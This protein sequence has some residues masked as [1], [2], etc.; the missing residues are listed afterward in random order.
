MTKT[1]LSVLAVLAVGVGGVVLI[2]SSGGNAGEVQSA[3]QNGTQ[4]ASAA[5]PR[6]DSPPSASGNLVVELCDGKTAAEIPG[7]KE[8]ETPSREQARAVV[9]H[10]MTDW[11]RKNPDASW[12][13]APMRVAQ[14]AG[15]A[16]TSGSA[17]APA[18]ATAPEIA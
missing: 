5:M 3:D 12:D 15:A 6:H 8:G 9:D 7:V 11:R 4:V 17:A 13:D 16:G 1:I 14:A 2:G 18:V 10:L